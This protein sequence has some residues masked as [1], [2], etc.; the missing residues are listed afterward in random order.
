MTPV[1]NKG[2]YSSKTAC[3]TNH[4]DTICTQNSSTKCWIGKCDTKKINI[5]MN[6]KKLAMKAI[7][8]NVTIATINHANKWMRILIAGLSVVKK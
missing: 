8:T 7:K 2:E 5:T 4:P 1:C 3:E 6:P